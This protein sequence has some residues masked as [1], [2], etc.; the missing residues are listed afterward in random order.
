[1]KKEKKDNNT[2]YYIIR[3]FLKVI[4]VLIMKPTVVHKNRIPDGGYLYAGTHTSYF[5][6]FELGYTTK[7]CVHYLAKIEL[8]KSKL[9]NFFFR[10]TGAIPVDRKNKNPEA[11]NEAIQKLKENK[12]VCVFPEGTINKTKE[13]IMPFKYGAVSIARKSGKPIVPFAIVGKPKPFNYK[14]KIIIGKPYYVTTDDFVKGFDSLNAENIIVF[15][16]NS[17]I[18]LA[19]S[20]AAKYYDKAK[21][22][23]VNSKSLAQ[24]YSALT[25]LDT[26]SGD[27]EKIL[28]EIDK[29]IRNV[30]TCLVT[31]SIRDAVIDDLVIKKDEY[32]GI[33]NGKMTACAVTKE[34]VI[35]EMLNS[36]D[37]EEKEIITIIYGADVT[38]E[39]LIKVENYIASHYENLEVDMV[40]GKQEVYSY[41][42][43][44]E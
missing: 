3:P 41:I 24:G 34:E 14:T 29:V 27:T 20:Q 2:L 1:M 7:K 13:Y 10:S 15:P 30:T 43:S 11:K 38:G 8:F 32:I 22:Y 6:A 35:F 16:N 31:Y 18:I 12:I 36:I 28:A 5:D 4:F 33:V 25:T 21:V 23:V 19:A 44:I 26:S 9:G 17:N 40:E 39:D 37:I 42:L